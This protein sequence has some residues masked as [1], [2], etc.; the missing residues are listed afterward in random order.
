M[1]KCDKSQLNFILLFSISI[2][3]RLGLAVVNRE[4]NDN[5]I[6]VIRRIMETWRLPIMYECRECFNP[7]LFYFAAA[8]L[9]QSLNV[10]EL[11]LQILII[12]LLNFS[13]GVLTLFIIYKFIREYPSENETLKLITFGLVALNPKIIAIN[14]QVSNDTFVI[15][16][17]TL[18]LYFA[19]KFIKFRYQKHFWLIIFSIILAISTKVTGIIVFLAIIIGF[20][21]AVRVGDEKISRKL[22]NFAILLIAVVT[23][24]TL[25]P[26]SQIITNTQKFGSPFVSSVA[27]LPLPDFFKQTTHYQGYQFRP[28]IVSIQDGFF[29]FKISDLLKYPLITNNRD[30]YPPQRTSFWTMLYADSNSL[31]FQNWPISW[32]TK[33]DENFAISRG[34]FILASLATLILITGFLFELITFL[35]ALFSGDK[36]KMRSQSYAIFLITSGG[37]IVFLM[38]STLLYRDF[39]YVK[40]IY[41][42]PG[43]LAFTW[44]FLRGFDYIS[45]LLASVGRWGKWLVNGWLIV[46]LG[47]YVWD[48]VAMISQ[49]SLV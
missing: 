29:T 30:T 27:W 11:S 2:I 43:L 16:F 42:L 19:N 21:L 18:A 41:I 7:K 9:L 24:T 20:L 40:L 13:A 38:V 39:S 15:L 1:K 49:L 26:L 6:I 3:L 22:T 5:H 25:N 35:K 28:G 36:S 23:L 48:V 37:Y 14:S 8:A 34:I 12:Q 4:A 10:T 31:H 47:F 44:L 46:L 32:Q 17:S 33:N 45:H